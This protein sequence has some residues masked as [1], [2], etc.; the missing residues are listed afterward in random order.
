MLL[1]LLAHAGTPGEAGRAFAAGATQLGMPDARLVQRE[2]LGKRRP[3]ELS[4]GQR[5]RVALAQCLDR[6]VGV[7]ERVAPGAVG[8]DR[9]LDARVA[10]RRGRLRA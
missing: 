1:S 3:S 9:E 4:G 8:R 2:A 5:Q 6:R 7:V 10:A